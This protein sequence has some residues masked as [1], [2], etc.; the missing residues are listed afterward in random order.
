MSTKLPSDEITPEHVFL[1]RRRCLQAAAIGGSL[2][3][4]LAADRNFNPIDIDVVL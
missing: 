2:P 3:I 1:N 4:S